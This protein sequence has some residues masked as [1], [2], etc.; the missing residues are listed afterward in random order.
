MELK[1]PLEH[2]DWQNLKG[3]CISCGY[4]CQR[5][6]LLTEKLYE[7]SV[8][9][10]SHGNLVSHPDSP[11]STVIWC[12]VCKEPLH[13]EFRR[14][15]KFYDKTRDNSDI[16]W[17]II[18]RD[19]KCPKW[20]P[21]TPFMSPKEHLEEMKLESLQRFNKNMSI[22]LAIVAF[23]TLAVGIAAIIIALN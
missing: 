23:S 1:R 15:T 3:V 17:E 4:L 22:F 20:I 12:F 19:I 7:A 16:S 14:L 6:D 2:K 9:S 10:R 5:T 18:T 11:R 8:E 13:E 21:Y